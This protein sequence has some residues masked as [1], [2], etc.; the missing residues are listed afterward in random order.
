MI[1]QAELESVIRDI[2]GVAAAADLDPTHISDD[3]D[4]QSENSFL[5]RSYDIDRLHA[6]DARDKVF[7]AI[8]KALAARRNKPSS[9]RELATCIMKHEFTLLGGA[10]PYATV[11]S[12]IS[13]HFKRIFE[14]T[15]PRPPILGRVAHEKHTRKYFYYVS[16]AHE[17]EDFQRKVRAGIIPTQPVVSATPSSRRTKT[18]KPRCMVPAIAVETD[19]AHTCRTRR[20]TSAGVSSAH[21]AG[22]AN[23]R[24]SHGEVSSRD[25]L[26]RRTSYG[27]SAESASDSD[28]N[29]YARKRFKSVRSAVACTYPKRRSR[30]VDEARAPHA[31]RSASH[32]DPTALQ[33]NDPDH[34][35]RGDS[36]GSS[37]LRRESAGPRPQRTDRG[38]GKW[39]SAYTSSED[40]GS[41]SAW[42]DHTDPGPSRPES[43]SSACTSEQAVEP[44]NAMLLPPVPHTTP[45]ASAS[46]DQTPF[47][48]ATSP[49]FHC[50]TD[51]MQAASP[52]LLPRSLM[53]IDGGMF[54]PG[55][56]SIAQKDIPSA[57][58][59]PLVTPAI[60]V[61]SDDSV[62]PAHPFLLTQKPDVHNDTQQT[63]PTNSDTAVTEPQEDATQGDS[64]KDTLT[65]APAEL[66]PPEE[67]AELDFSFHDL[68]DAELMSV[69]E[70]DTL[71]TTS[72]PATH[73]GGFSALETIPES[74][75]DAK[76]CAAQSDDELPTRLTQKLL[77]L[78]AGPVANEAC[79]D[80]APKVRMEIHSAPEPVERRNPE[81]SVDKTALDSVEPTQ[82]LESEEP[83]QVLD[84]VEPTRVLASNTD[85]HDGGTAGGSKIILPDPFADIPATAMVA[86][87]VTVSPRIVLTIVETVPVYMTVITTTEPAAACRGKWIVRRHRLLRLVENGYVNASS[88][89]LAGGVASEQERSIV[90]SLEVGRFKWRRPQSKLYGTWIPLPRARALAAT[91]SLNHRLGPFLNDN[92]EAYFPAP[93]P[94]TFIRH[95]IMPFFPDQSVILADGSSSAAEATARE[96][97]L[98]IEFQHLVNST[99]AARSQSISRS[100]TFG[101]TARGTPSPSI[102]QSLAARAAPFGLVGSAKTIFGADDRQLNSLLQLLSAE[103]PMLGSAD[104]RASEQTM[105]KDEVEHVEPDHN[106]ESSLSE[107]G[108]VK[109]PLTP[110]SA[111]SAELRRVTDVLAQSTINGTS[112]DTNPQAKSVSPPTISSTQRVTRSR[113][114]TVSQQ[115]S[116]VAKD[117]HD[118]PGVDAHKLSAAIA[119]SLDKASEHPVSLDKSEHSAELSDDDRA[120]EC[121]LDDLDMSMVMPGS[122]SEADLIS[123]STPPSPPSAPLRFRRLSTAPLRISR[124]SSISS[125]ID[126]EC[127]TERSADTRSNAGSAENEGTTRQY[128]SA[129]GTFNARLAQTMEAFGFT[130]TAKT[131]LLLR[132]RAAAAAKS[133]GR[134]QAVAPYLL[135]RNGPGGSAGSSAVKRGQRTGSDDADDAGRKRA[136]VV[137]IPRSKPPIP[138]MQA[139]KGR[140]RA[141]AAAPDPSVVL[142]LASAIYN[143]TLNMAAQNQRT[144]E[145]PAKPAVSS[146]VDSGSVS[147]SQPAPQ[148]TPRPQHPQQH[149]RPPPHTPGAI[150]A[151]KPGVRPQMRS[152]AGHVSPGQPRPSPNSAGPGCRPPMRPPMRPPVANGRPSPGTRPPLRRPPTGSPQQIQRPNGVRPPVRPTQPMVRRPVLAAQQPRPLVRPGVSPRPVPRPVVRPGTVASP[153]L[154][155]RPQGT[156]S[157]SEQDSPA[158][159]QQQMVRNKPAA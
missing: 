5:P 113:S 121:T 118:G 36:A 87:K 149:P 79:V 57:S 35:V 20:A 135:Y 58:L 6:D 70:L 88:L 16:S 74:R 143:H 9:P 125:V 72:H 33:G 60:V 120:M 11:S 140:A 47:P 100:S 53:A 141:R 14:H 68:M 90:L 117:T 77:A 119:S 24:V 150:T 10:T 50:Y 123:R 8:L 157:G 155:T 4:E 127:D 59:T 124:S 23:R 18:K 85:S 86:T 148:Q 62:V 84:S 130:G 144:T 61:H 49:S 133:T 115:P 108:H 56:P 116:A 71:W 151:S 81:I 54:D 114:R 46:P 139:H 15:P 96:A 98:G 48:P 128:H 158:I 152:P 112:K 93:L 34:A 105:P 66:T 69:N 147:V 145:A 82:V 73:T 107:T 64:D 31:R 43:R 78:S 17:Q 67:P 28:A 38:T 41:R 2:S 37:S 39:R 104:S 95:L 51:E 132:L 21:S 159:R 103:G 134:Q 91:C 25:E 26:V 131:N 122:D 19:M 106:E 101:A 80:P 97:G 126:P 111:T 99:V 1:S 27:D 92:L 30:V 146:P 52:L 45:R 129:S 42:S 83:T 40:E 3:E 109:A 7:V 65:A 153:D 89:L 44:A 63:T 75:E 142:R 29:P 110:L 55:S 12:R 154:R 102:I 32:G 137:R 94:T 136:R 76:D 138:P 13:Q 22:R 156:S